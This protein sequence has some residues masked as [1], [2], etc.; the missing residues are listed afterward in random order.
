M[1]A[2]SIF[3]TPAWIQQVGWTLI[4]FLWQGTVI[5]ILFAAARG[6]FGRSMTAQSRYTMAFITLTVMAVAPAITFIARP[7]AAPISAWPLSSPDSWQRVLPWCVA[8]WLIGVVLFSIRLIGGWRFTSRLR[9][10]GVRPAPEEWQHKLEGLIM[11]MGVS[12]PVQLLVSSLVEVPTVI[13]WLRPLILVPVGALTGLPSVHV[14]ALLIHELAH[15]RRLDYLMNMVQSI[16]EAVLFYHPAVW[17]ISDQIR[18][19]RELCCDDIA[20]VA[21]GDVLTYVRALAEMESHRPVQSQS[22]MAANGGSLPNRIR[23]LIGQQPK[24]AHTLPGP[25]AAVVMSLLCLFGLGAMA[26]T[27]EPRVLPSTVAIVQPPA[28]ESAAVSKRPILSTLLFGP[29]GPAPESQNTGTVS[30]IVIATGTNTGIGGATVTIAAGNQQFRATTGDDGRFSIPKV[31]AGK[32]TPTASKDGYY[33]PLPF[34]LSGQAIPVEADRAVRNVKLDLVRFSALSGRMVDQNGDAAADIDV[35]L[36]QEEYSSDG[37]PYL[38]ASAPLKTNDQGEFRTEGTNI[39]FLPGEYYIVASAPKGARDFAP[40]YYPG[41]ARIDDAMK[42]VVPQ[43][44]DLNGVTFALSRT[45]LH[46]VSF[47]LLNAPTTTGLPIRIETQMRRRDGVLTPITLDYDSKS[48]NSYVVPRLAPGSYYINV[49]WGPGYDGHQPKTRLDV[50]VSD[51]DVDLG[52]LNV[53]PIR[54]ITGRVTMLGS[55]IDVPSGISTISILQWDYTPGT[56]VPVASDG[57]FSAELPEGH[58]R[59]RLLQLARDSYVASVQYGTREVVDTGIVVDGDPPGSLKIGIASGVG[60]VLGAVRNVRGDLISSAR[61]ILL[62]SQNRRNNTDLIYTTLTDESGAFSISNVPPGDYSAIALE[63]LPSSIQ[64]FR[65]SN[66]AK[67]AEYMKQF[68]K[69]EMKITVGVGEKKQINL[70][71]V[72]NYK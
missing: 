1:S 70:R 49:T 8:A 22:V 13:G 35:R 62:P 33:F 51:L 57:T 42:V 72:A 7:S 48:K 60:N 44:Q 26:A 67:N 18:S 41:V 43:N 20:V 29:V 14:E 59:I 11:R 40:T 23:R 63:I 54:N 31:P 34:R 28:P 24:T 55:D 15:I 56:T 69:Q 46:S 37:T 68:E 16:T 38:K 27:G 52:T 17:W 71:S 10:Y 12:R 21:T 65:S 9:N 32:Y 3:P 36:L 64:W 19:E 30:G 25:G 58:Y 4:Q 50:T 2:P 47:T 61:V 53:A 5:A 6:L 39:W 45:S 66:A